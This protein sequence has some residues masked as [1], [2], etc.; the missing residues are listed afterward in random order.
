[1]MCVATPSF[2]EPPSANRNAPLLGQKIPDSA[3]KAF[4]QGQELAS[5]NQPKKAVEA[6]AEAVRLAP[7]YRDA[8]LYYAMQ[9]DV[10][11]DHGRAV[12]AY[13][14]AAKAFP[15]DAEI[16]AEWGT[17]LIML[18]RFDAAV[19]VLEKAVALAPKEL[20]WLT[21]LAYA[22][23]RAG[24][25][26]GALKLYDQAFSLGFAEPIARRQYGD[27]L[28]KSGELTRAEQ[29]YSELLAKTP[30]DRD[31]LYR[32]AKVRS[33]NGNVKGAAEDEAAVQR[34]PKT[35]DAK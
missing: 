15:K 33:A 17:T 31:L 9:L 35:G 11:G 6:F 5:Q 32:R 30:N 3:Q 29:V 10:S 8:H 24:D 21:D 18:K 34:L 4:A 12:S 27:A 22:K 13:E 14:A 19:K 26:Q 28:A 7:H 1:M 2:A 16:H 20:G 25:T 23:N